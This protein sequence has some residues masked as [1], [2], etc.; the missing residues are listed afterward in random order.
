MR[1]RVSRSKRNRRCTGELQQVAS[2]V[3]EILGF[4]SWSLVVIEPLQLLFCVG[5]AIPGAK[6]LA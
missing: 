6:Q 2:G 5:G 1:L 4:H 3:V